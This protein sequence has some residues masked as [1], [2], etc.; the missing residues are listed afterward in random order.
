MTDSKNM[1]AISNTREELTDYQIFIVWKPEFTLGIPIIDEQHRGIVS[2]I[3]SL[4]YAMQH[5]IGEAML[6][7][8]IGMVKEYTRIHFHIEED[9]LRKD[10]FPDLAYH[11]DLHRELTD[12][13][14][15]VEVVSL[16]E[17]DP[18]QFMD[19]LRL[20]WIEHICNKDRVFL[21]HRMQTQDRK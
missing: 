1:S 19:F 21:Q 7:P 9:F 3:N 5:N 2:S 13:L 20:W 18:H 12:T 15:L 14:A 8:I 4:H 10:G 6:H 16:K 17:N 11:Q